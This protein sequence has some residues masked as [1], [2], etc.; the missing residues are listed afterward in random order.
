VEVIMKKGLGQA[1]VVTV[2]AAVAVAWVGGIG[3]SA[4]AMA[5]EPKSAAG[6]RL[7]ESIQRAIRAEGPF[8]T[9]AE[10]SVIRAKCG[11]R[12]G[13]WDGYDV[14]M[15]NR[16]LICR[17]GRRVADPEVR[18]LMEVAGP[19]IGRRVSAVMA[20]PE[21]S[22]AIANV[23]SEATREAMAELGKR[24]WGHRR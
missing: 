3:S 12:P 14:N 4:T 6:A 7:G 17:N 9:S 15:T 18:A 10:Q 23:A 8:F 24:S 11:Y 13:E 2:S 21:V 19:R 20:R 1:L 16:V 22:E 5:A